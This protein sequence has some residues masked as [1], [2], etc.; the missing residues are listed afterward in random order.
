[1]KRVIPY[2]THSGVIQ[3]EGR[4]L[5]VYKLSTGHTVVDQADLY[6]FME[7]FGLI[8]SPRYNG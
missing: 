3:L 4:D 5:R 2:V 6:D 1:M 8:V 7:A